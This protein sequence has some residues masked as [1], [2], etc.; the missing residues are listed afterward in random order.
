M[1]RGFSIFAQESGGRDQNSSGA[2][3]ALQRVM[4]PECFLQIIEPAARV[5]QPFYSNNVGSLNLGSEN[6]ARAH[7]AAIDEY[8]A[9]AADTVFTTDM[10]AVLF[11]AVAQ[12]IGK[13]HPGLG[14]H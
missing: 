7:G 1:L 10:S 6:Q 12:Q 14:L 5:G 2:E 9:S 3:A 11:E 4:F 13:L 8:R